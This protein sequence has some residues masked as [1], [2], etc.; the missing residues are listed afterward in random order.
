MGSINTLL[1]DAFFNQKAWDDE[2]PCYDVMN[3]MEAKGTERELDEIGI[4]ESDTVLD[5]GCGSGRMSIPMARRAKRV[6]AIDSSE[7]MIEICNRN[8]NDSG[9]SN[10][11]CQRLDWENDDDYEKLPQVD[12]IIQA[13]WSGGA[14]SLKKYMKKGK[15][16]VIIEWAKN[17]PRVVRDTLFKD[18]F[19][20]EAI[21]EHPELAPFD[22]MAYTNSNEGYRIKEARNKKLRDELKEAGIEL[23]SKTVQGGMEYFCTSKEELEKKLL[24]LSTHPHL[25]NLEKF[26]ENIV[27]FIE[28]KEDGWLFYYPT[29]SKIEW[30][31]TIIEV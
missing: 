10:I 31:N 30:F 8:I 22:P 27:P 3:S 26:K 25:V 23:H 7:A 20:E 18:C 28:E 6:I 2:S 1:G 13:R 29:W 14:S 11:D 17:S 16:I 21:Q 5:I 12:I 4:K 9:L 15:K 19:S 24:Y